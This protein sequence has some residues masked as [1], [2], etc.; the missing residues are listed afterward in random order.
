MTG[1]HRATVVLA[2]DAAE[3]AAARRFVRR[4][5]GDRAAADVAGDLQL[6]TSELF[7]N[8]VEHGAGAQ[9]EVVV[10]AAET[11]CA[12]TV[13]SVGPADVGPAADWAVAEASSVTGRGLGIVRELADDLVVERTDASFVVTA[14]CG[15]HRTSTA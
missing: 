9:V 1:V 11:S 8:A 5:L 15:L 3:V 4:E 10:E 6:I 7:T 13:R 12:V 2:A 14:R